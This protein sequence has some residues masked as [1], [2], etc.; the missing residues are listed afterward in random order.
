MSFFNHHNKHLI[1]EIFIFKFLP[2]ILFFFF[3]SLI[4][5]QNNDYINNDGIGYL[6]V[7]DL[8]GNNQLEKTVNLNVDLFYPNLILKI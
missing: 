7:A 8:I 4:L 3:I 1:L 5:Y 2:L 6:V